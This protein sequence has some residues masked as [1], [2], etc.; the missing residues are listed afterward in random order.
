MGDTLPPGWKPF[1]FKKIERHTT[2]SLVKD[3][4]TVV[5][6][7]TAEASA[8]GLTREIKI[9]PKEYPIIQ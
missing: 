6:K 7:A 1:T 3:N 8:S 4:D 2:Y 9:N 5:I